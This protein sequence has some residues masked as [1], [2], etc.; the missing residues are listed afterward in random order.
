MTTITGTYTNKEQGYNYTI[1][2][3]FTLTKEKIT[4]IKF[5]GTGIK[6]S[7]TLTKTIEP[8]ILGKKP[9]EAQKITTQ[10]IEQTTKTE[11]HLAESITHTLH[12][13]IRAYNNEQRGKDPFQEAFESLLNY[14]E[15][16]QPP[17]HQEIG[18]CSCHSDSTKKH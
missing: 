14:Q 12:A 15:G 2:C 4:G 1:T 8:L 10:A 6:I 18:D 17:S 11:H 13:T 16:Y 3:T 9:A 7:T 5:T